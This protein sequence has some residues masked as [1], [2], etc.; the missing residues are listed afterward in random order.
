MSVFPDARFRRGRRVLHCS[1]QCRR[2]LATPP[3]VCRAGVIYVLGRSDRSEAGLGRLRGART[4]RRTDSQTD[5]HQGPK[6]TVCAVPSLVPAGR[7][8]AAPTFP[9]SR[10]VSPAP[11]ALLHKSAICQTPS[12]AAAAAGVVSSSEGGCRVCKQGG[13]GEGMA[14]WRQQC[15][16]CATVRLLHNLCI[17][18]GRVQ[19][20]GAVQQDPPVPALAH[21][22]KDK[23]QGGIGVVAASSV[24]RRRRVAACV[25]LL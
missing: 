4:D 23:P 25:R 7:L 2:R 12:G 11:E 19:T 9:K 5:R 8:Y 15:G 21:L 24:G 10:P 1:V 20:G 6:C 14:P 16:S 13:A 3:F 22:G 17:T 18:R